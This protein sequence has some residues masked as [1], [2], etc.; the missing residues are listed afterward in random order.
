MF[1]SQRLRP[2]SICLTDK[3]CSKIPF[4]KETDYAQVTGLCA[5]CPIMRKIDVYAQKLCVHMIA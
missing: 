1:L 2:V 3:S 4:V 5:L